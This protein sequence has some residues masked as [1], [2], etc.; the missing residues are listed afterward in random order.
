M[1]YAALGSFV[2]ADP[3]RVPVRR[4]DHA[5]CSATSG[6]WPRRRRPTASPASQT[7]ARFDEELALEWRRAH[8]VGD[9]LAF[10]LLDLDDFKQVNDTHGHQAGDAVLRAVGEVLLGGVRQVDLAGRYGGEEFALILP[11]TD[12]KGALR[13]AERLRV[14]LETTSV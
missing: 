5:H 4:S 2:A 1:R 11:E 7:A 6:E 13:L 8:R 12:L 10:I 9:S 3:G 14:A